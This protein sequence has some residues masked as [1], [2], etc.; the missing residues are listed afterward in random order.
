[1]QQRPRV[2]TVPMK[3]SEEPQPGPHVIP[4][5]NHLP[6]PEIPPPFIPTPKGWK[7]VA[8][9]ASHLIPLEP[10]PFANYYFTMGTSQMK[11][12]Y[13]HTVNHISTEEY[14][15]QAVIDEETERAMEY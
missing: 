11:G 4:P 6:P 13:L 9:S 3:K 5:D 12:W 15:A 1:M 8:L 14:L 7:N 2:E 10:I